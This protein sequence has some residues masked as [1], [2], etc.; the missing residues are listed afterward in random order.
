MQMIRF[1]QQ[2]IS[3]DSLNFYNYNPHKYSREQ[4]FPIG[5]NELILS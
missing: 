4:I 1:V 3:L 5:R 2:I